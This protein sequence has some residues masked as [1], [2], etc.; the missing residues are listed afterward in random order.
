M[1]TE[2]PH[3]AIDKDI[4]THQFESVNLDIIDYVYFEIDKSDMERIID[5]YYYYNGK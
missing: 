5:D 3:Q 1:N 2:T 4:E